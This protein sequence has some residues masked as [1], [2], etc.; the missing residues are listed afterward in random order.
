LK[1]E[2]AR[3]LREERERERIKRGEGAGQR[4]HGLGPIVGPYWSERRRRPRSSHWWLAVTP[5]N[6]KRGS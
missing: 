5:A 3:E 4:T 2:G 1:R 6:R